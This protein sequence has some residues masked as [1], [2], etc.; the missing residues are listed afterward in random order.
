MLHEAAWHFYQLCPSNTSMFSISCRMKRYL[1]ETGSLISDCKILVPA[2]HDNI[3]VH[4]PPFR[5]ANR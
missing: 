3:T 4:L 2:Q 1:V 5:S